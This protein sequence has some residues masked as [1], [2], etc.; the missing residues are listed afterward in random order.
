LLSQPTITKTTDKHARQLLTAD[1]LRRIGDRE[2]VII[3]TNKRPLRTNRFWYEAAPQ[4]AKVSG[5]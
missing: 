4:T 1:E 5:C 3:T 2:Q